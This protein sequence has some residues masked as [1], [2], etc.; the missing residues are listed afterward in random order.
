MTQTQLAA[1]LE[2]VEQ[3]KSDALKAFGELKELADLFAV[4]ASQV[5]DYAISE[6]QKYPKL[7][8]NA[9]GFELRAG[10]GRYSYPNSPNINSLETALKQAQEAAK[11]ALKAAENG[12]QMVDD[13][14][15]VIAPAEKTYS[16][17]ILACIKSK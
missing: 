16:S 4:A 1:L 12:N 5:K 6:A 10:A 3:G 13:N 15:E 2:D 14:G 17:T 11:A 7:Q 9:M 8:L